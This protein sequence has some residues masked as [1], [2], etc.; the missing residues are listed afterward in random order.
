MIVELHVWALL[1]CVFWGV[2]CTACLKSSVL[3]PALLYERAQLLLCFGDW[4]EWHLYSGVFSLLFVVCGFSCIAK[5]SWLQSATSACGTPSKVRLHASS[6][7][8]F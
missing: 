1:Y 8:R 6:L 4:S 5:H 7:N 3:P 2:A